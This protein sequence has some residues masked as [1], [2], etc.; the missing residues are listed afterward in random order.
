MPYLKN[1][2]FLGYC[3]GGI[4]S[5]RSCPAADFIYIRRQN[6]GM[7]GIKNDA[8]PCAATCKFSKN[9]MFELL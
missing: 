5:A 7:F 8:R 2:P 9:A 3:R 6:N 1:V 4:F